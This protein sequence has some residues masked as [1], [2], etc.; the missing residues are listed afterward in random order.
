MRREGV[1]EKKLT[2]RERMREDK[3]RKKKDGEGR[4]TLIESETISNIAYF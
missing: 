1:R 3:E 4:D 2:G